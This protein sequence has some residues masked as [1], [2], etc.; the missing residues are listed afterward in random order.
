MQPPLCLLD[1]Q[2]V[3][4]VPSRLLLLVDAV[5]LHWQSPAHKQ[6]AQFSLLDHIARDIGMLLY[7]FAQ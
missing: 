1:Y 5:T 7:G 6:G 3:S 4:G 2:P